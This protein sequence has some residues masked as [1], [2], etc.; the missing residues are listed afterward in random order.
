MLCHQ[1]GVSATYDVLDP[2]FL[3]DA[4]SMQ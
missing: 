1:V 2:D 4:Q 3:C